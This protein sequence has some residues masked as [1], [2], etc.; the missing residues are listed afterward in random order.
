MA[1]IVG[2][3]VVVKVRDQQDMI[4]IYRTFDRFSGCGLQK[5]IK[6]MEVILKLR[7]VEMPELKCPTLKVQYL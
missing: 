1:A 6:L 7:D 4:R 5:F 3:I 2:E